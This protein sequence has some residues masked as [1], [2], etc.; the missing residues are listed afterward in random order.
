[1]T[2]VITLSNCMSLQTFSNISNPCPLPENIKHSPFT[3]L[4][5]PE[6][7]ED[8]Y[9][10][11]SLLIENPWYWRNGIASRILCWAL[12][13]HNLTVKQQIYFCLPRNV[14]FYITKYAFQTLQLP[15]IPHSLQD[16]NTLLY[17]DKTSP[18]ENHW[19]K[20]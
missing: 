14:I 5:P 2:A 16:F 10:T 17:G 7:T 4:L 9:S 20:I 18:L 11:R 6:G 13:F 1:M 15:S 12:P 8:L 19:T 3:V